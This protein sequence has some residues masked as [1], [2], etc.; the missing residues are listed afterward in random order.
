RERATRLLTLVGPGGV[1]KTRLAL[2]VT[3]ALA[4][5][6]IDGVCV[7]SL[8]SLRDPDL[9]PAAIVAA[10]GLRATVGASFTDLLTTQL[11]DKQMLLLLDNY[12][13]LALA[14]PVVAALLATCP[15]LIALTTSRASLRVR[16]E[17]EY[18]VLPLALP[19]HEDLASVAALARVAA[20]RL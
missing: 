8:A 6:F 3:Q 5:T 16:G 2:E 9:V 13:H 17:R 15:D 7:V 18:P 4:D 20:V 14:A 12:E 11:R 1:G 19:C 10:L